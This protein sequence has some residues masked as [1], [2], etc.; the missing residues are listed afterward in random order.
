MLFG[1]WFTKE[2]FHLLLLLIVEFVGGRRYGR[3]AD[4]QIRSLTGPHHLTE[5][6]ENWRPFFS[7]QWGPGHE[8]VAGTLVTEICA[9]IFSLVTLI[10]LLLSCVRPTLAGMCWKVGEVSLGL[11]LLSQIIPLIPDQ[12]NASNREVRRYEMD[13]WGYLQHLF[14]HRPKRRCL[15]EKEVKP[16]VY[17]FSYGH[18]RRYT[19]TGKAAVPVEVGKRYY[20]THDGDGNPYFWTI[21]SH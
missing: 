1:G 4:K 8:V 7:F 11:F 10:L 14:T 16:G 12:L 2:A 17:E 13:W 18:L 21:R 15:V 19:R 5:V 20:A 3:V 9:Y 6:P